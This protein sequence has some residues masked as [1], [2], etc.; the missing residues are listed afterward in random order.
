MKVE[1]KHPLL[2]LQNVAEKLRVGSA[3]AGNKAHFHIECVDAPSPPPEQFRGWQELSAMKQAEARRLLGGHAAAPRALR[4]ARQAHERTSPL[5]TRGAGSLLPVRARVG[6]AERER[7]RQ[8]E[9]SEEAKG[10]ERERERANAQRERLVRVLF[11][12]PFC[13]HSLY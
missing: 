5:G 12:S 13:R 2:L 10:R 11:L 4:G 8:R 7:E 1:G 9:M 3:A 6:A